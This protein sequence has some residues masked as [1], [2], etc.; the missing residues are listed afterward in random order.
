MHMVRDTARSKES[1][2]DPR[3]TRTRRALI[4]AGR[5]LLACRPVEDLTVMDV[6]RTARLS[7]PSFYNH[8]SSKEELVEAVAADFFE[9]DVAYKKGVFDRA[10][11]PAEAIATNAIHTLMVARRDP[12]VAWV[13]VRS[14]AM[15]ELP[16]AK[17]ED[18]LVRMIAAGV[19]KGR[20]RVANAEV[21]AS[22][23]RGAASSLLRDTLLG[24]TP[25]DVERQLAELV[26]RMLGLNARE[27]RTVAERAMARVAA[28]PA[29]GT[30]VSLR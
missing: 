9:S 6:V 24:G 15:R 10:A 19:R 30:P 20:L 14:G 16:R 5:R 3:W 8:F 7:Q 11:D 18:G 27:A 12:A 21:A 2:E 13:M 1:Q 28:E 23:I 17:A 4:D 29:R 25:P 26:L 22:A